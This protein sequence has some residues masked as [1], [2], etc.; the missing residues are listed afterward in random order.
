MSRKTIPLSSKVRFTQEHAT[1]VDRAFS[2]DYFDEPAQARRELVRLAIKKLGFSIKTAT[3]DILNSIRAARCLASDPKRLAFINSPAGRN[4]VWLGRWPL[5]ILAM[6]MLCTGCDRLDRLTG[7]DIEKD[8]HQT[9][10]ITVACCRDNDGNDNLS[11]PSFL[12]PGHVAFC[13]EVR[14]ANYHDQRIN[15]DTYLAMHVACGQGNYKVGDQYYPP[16]GY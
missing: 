16:T 10:L 7:S 5:I 1:L 13:E 12:P 14:I 8:K 3:Q 11:Y 4:R 15:G 6:G 2:R 9:Q